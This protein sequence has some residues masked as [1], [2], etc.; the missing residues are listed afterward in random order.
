MS[1]L[2]YRSD[3]SERTSSNVIQFRQKTPS[4]TKEE[5]Y[6][7]DALIGNPEFETY[8][9]DMIEGI[10]ISNLATQA[11]LENIDKDNPFDSIYFAELTPDLIIHADLNR[12]RYLS[13]KIIDKSDSLKFNDGWE[14]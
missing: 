1:N 7:L 11:A 10:V 8:L 6:L 2:A 12:I 4:N 9:K 14:D 3:P 5:N 13:K